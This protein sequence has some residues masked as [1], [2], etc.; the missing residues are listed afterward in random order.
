MLYC[1]CSSSFPSGLHVTLWIERR[2]Q[3][4]CWSSTLCDKKWR[5]C[6][7]LVHQPHVEFYDESLRFQL[8]ENDLI[9]QKQRWL[10]SVSLPQTAYPSSSGLTNSFKLSE[11]LSG[12][13]FG[14]VMKNRFT[15]SCELFLSSTSI[16]MNSNLWKILQ[17]PAKEIAPPRLQ[18]HLFK[19]L[20]GSA[21]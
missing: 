7:C 2:I 1:S 16:W 15:P 8:I 4:G 10:T 20:L 12:S 17:Y 3:R 9:K 6:C 19:M 11:H 18:F 21:S 5:Q 14:S 13:L